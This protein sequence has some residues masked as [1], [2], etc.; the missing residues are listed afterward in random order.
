MPDTQQTSSTTDT[1]VKPLS[2]D[3]LREVNTARCEECY[4]GINE[5]NLLE[6]S[7]A[8]AGEAGEA[9]NV[10][11]KIK[12]ECGGNDDVWT[13]ARIEAFAE[14]LADTVIYADL[15]AARAGIDLGEAIRKKFNEKSEKRG[16]QFR[17]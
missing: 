7:G 8:M 13:Q 10:A 6:W 4:H 2:F 14:E 1:D 3:E 11:K 12:R 5:W 9:A 15:A 16:S 17:L